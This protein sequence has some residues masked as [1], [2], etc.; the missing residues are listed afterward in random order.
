[1]SETTIGAALRRQLELLAGRI[2][3]LEQQAAA[4]QGKALDWSAVDETRI[5][6]DVALDR[7]DED[8]HEAIGMAL[9]RTGEALKRRMTEG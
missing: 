7:L 9:R 5:D 4:A 1:M 2:E 8:V 6:L 3:R